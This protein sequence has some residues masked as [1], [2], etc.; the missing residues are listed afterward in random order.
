MDGTLLPWSF[1]FGVTGAETL[2]LSHMNASGVNAVR[3]FVHKLLFRVIL[4]VGVL[5]DTL[6]SVEA[7]VGPKSYLDVQ[8]RRDIF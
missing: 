2:S 4:K 6:G 3:E 8:K 5:D 7:L 1:A